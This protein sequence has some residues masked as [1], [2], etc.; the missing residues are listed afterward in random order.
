MIYSEK[1]VFIVYI[2]SALLLIGLICMVTFVNIGDFLHNYK[3]KGTIAAYYG[4]TAPSGWVTCDG[5]NGTPDLRGKFVYG[6]DKSSQLLLK[7]Y[8]SK[9]TSLFNNFMQDLETIEGGNNYQTLTSKTK[10]IDDY[11]HYNFTDIP[12]QDFYSR[13]NLLSFEVNDTIND[14][15]N[16]NINVI[17]SNN[18]DKN[19]TN[20]FIHNNLALLNQIDLID[21]EL[22]IATSKD[23]TEEEK[24]TQITKLKEDKLKERAL[25]VKDELKEDKNIIVTETPDAAGNTVTI[26]RNNIPIDL[27]DITQQDNFQTNLI[28]VEFDVSIIEEPEYRGFKYPS[29]KNI[30]ADNNLPPYYALI[31]IM[32][33]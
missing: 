9:D 31:F 23:I 15:N 29:N 24:K 8:K 18:P 28:D 17:I 33:T 14:I 2:I 4:V 11:Q 32:K 21:E 6:G 10:N 26:T 3:P 7:Y 16:N 12:I 1:Y 22:D 5:S 30:T 19:S 20:P 27:T 13:L 25:N